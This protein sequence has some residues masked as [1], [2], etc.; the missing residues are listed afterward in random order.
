MSVLPI[1][2]LSFPP[3]DQPLTSL[4]PAALTAAQPSTTA[5]AAD[6]QQQLSALP[7][8][9]FSAAVASPGSVSQLTG[10]V[11]QQTR[12]LLAPNAAL[13]LALPAA[14][15]AA[16]VQTVQSQLILAGMTRL[17]RRSETVD[18]VTQVL[19]TAFTPGWSAG[20]AAALPF[21]KRRPPVSAQPLQSVWSLSSSEL[22]EDELEDEDAVLQR[23]TER[24]QPS[25]SSVT[26]TADCG[27]S[28]AVGGRRKACKNCSCGL[29]EALA[30]ADEPEGGRQ[31][32]VAAKSACGNCSLGDAFRC[33]SCPFLGQPAFVNSKA[34][35]VKLQL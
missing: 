4:L 34:G 14:A 28:A 6:A 17:E 29:A 21:L 31:Q 3:S 11:L 32:P 8:A 10:L 25:A 2:Q 18:G 22:L 33:A 20:A 12:R 35:A 1:L 5:I 27:P 15:T 16:E 9:S 7:A 26:R 23:E 13:L 24:A 30:A 19:V